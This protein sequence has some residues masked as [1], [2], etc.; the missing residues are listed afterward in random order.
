MLRDTDRALSRSRR[1]SP[2][3]DHSPRRWSPTH[4]RHRVCRRDRS[5]D[6]NVQRSRDSKILAIAD[7]LTSVQ[8]LQISYDRWR[9][10]VW[11]VV[12]NDYVADLL[13]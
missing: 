4:D 8:Q 11:G 2:V 13:T 10:C 9:V 12:H 6:A 7:D 5:L 1:V 3:F